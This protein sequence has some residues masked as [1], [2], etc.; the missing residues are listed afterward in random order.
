MKTVYRK[1]TPPLIP[2]YHENGALQLIVA[3]GVTFIS[4]H[5]VRV[6][7]LIMG[8]E[9]DFV[10]NST[11]PNI[12]IS[13]VQLFTQKWWTI[14]TY[15]WVHHGFFDWFTNMIWLYCFA[16]VL[17]NLAGYKQIIPLFF[18]SLVVGGGFF[19]GSQLLSPHYFSPGNTYFLGSQAGVIALAFAA[20]ALSPSY[21]LHITPA[22]NIP[23]VLIVTLF[24]VI[25][26]LVYIPDQLNVLM[27]CLGGVATGVVYAALLKRNYRPGEWV[28][29]ALSRMERAATPNEH[30]LAEKK[31]RKRVEILRTM[32]EPKKGISQDRID[33]ILD[34]IN[35]HGY[36]AL[37]REEK[38]TLFRAS[39]D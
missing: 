35:D 33:Q 18:Y 37:S 11:F 28:Y 7:M 31:S 4:F 13:N 1:S 14:F 9:K 22:F 17:Q 5:F 15:G 30:E 36:Q 12:G 16:S 25:N 38:E 3:S 8:K 29:D 27:L 19:L 34:K 10:F 24:V 26:L 2:G 20:L 32:Y 6:V 39:K 23:L 21:R